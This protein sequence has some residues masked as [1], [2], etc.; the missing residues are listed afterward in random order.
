MINIK[1][2]HNC[3]IPE[4]IPVAVYLKIPKINAGKNNKI[5]VAMLIMRSY[6]C[7][8]L[9]ACLPIEYFAQ[10]NNVKIIKTADKRI[11]PIRV[12]KIYTSITI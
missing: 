8:K 12:F 7:S 11:N 9:I 2:K 3:Q 1:A 5:I 6:G 4:I 10:T